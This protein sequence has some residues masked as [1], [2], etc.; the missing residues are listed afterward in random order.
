MDILLLA[1]GT[2]GDVTPVITLGKHL[3]SQGHNVTIGT[4]PYLQEIVKT[5]G[6]LWSKIG[7]MATADFEAL[8]RNTAKIPSIDEKSRHFVQGFSSYG[9]TEMFR[10]LT[11]LATKVDLVIGTPHVMPLLKHV[12]EDLEIDCINLVHFLMGDIEVTKMPNIPTIFATSTQLTPSY[13]I[14]P[15]SQIVTGLWQQVS[16]SNLTPKIEHFVKMKPTIAFAFGS[17]DFLLTE[18]IIEYLQMLVKSTNIISLR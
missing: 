1:T 5:S 4:P 17:I 13:S 11:M 15:D 14:P 12:Y 3:K 6:L 16:D 10:D 9:L 8:K 7:S 2:R 18:E